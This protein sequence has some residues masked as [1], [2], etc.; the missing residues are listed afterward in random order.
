MSFEMTCYLTSGAF[1]YLNVDIKFN[2]RVDHLLVNTYVP[3]ILSVVMS[4][5]SLNISGAFPCLKV[6]IEFNRRV[7][8]YLVNTYVP[9]I[10]SVVMSWV[11]F[12]IDS[13]VS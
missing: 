2:R 12:W 4:W 5:V 1:S 3:S 9:S 8:I 11:S 6:D 7:G 10:L 13:K